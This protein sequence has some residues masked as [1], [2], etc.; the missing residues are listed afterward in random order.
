[1]SNV[2]PWVHVLQSCLSKKLSSFV[3]LIPPHNFINLFKFT[4]ENPNCLWSSYKAKL[5]FHMSLRCTVIMVMWP[6][7]GWKVTCS[8]RQR[9]QPLR[10]A[11][12]TP[13]TVLP[14]FYNGDY[15]VTV[16]SPCSHSTAWWLMEWEFR[17][18]F[19]LTYHCNNMY[20]H[21]RDCCLQNCIKST[22]DISWKDEARSNQHVL[23]Q[24]CFKC[25]MSTA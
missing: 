10:S 7:G 8:H 14:A 23:N 24:R 2:N 20:E 21:F 13:V 19:F 12:S 18:V 1:M 25:L 3:Y 5:L 4:L 15:T 22:I 9:Q 17:C 11:I 16:Q 6:H